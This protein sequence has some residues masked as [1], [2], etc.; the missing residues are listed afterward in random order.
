LVIRYAYLWRDETLR[1]REEGSK[2]RPC[3]VV[4]AVRDRH[5]ERV[6]TVAPITHR[7]PPDGSRAVEMPMATKRRL[8]LDD[9]PSW[10][11][12]N[13][14]NEFVRPGPDL[15]PVTLGRP[16]RFAYGLLPAK[17]YHAIKASL[18]EHVRERRANLAKR[19]G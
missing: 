18:I 19:G 2:D 12:T 9:H 16:A 11:I 6:V 15:R 7:P 5:G 13:D 3:V 1:G 14:L 17:L 8:G 4:L 10:I